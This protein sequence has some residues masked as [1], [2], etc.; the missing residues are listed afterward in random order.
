MCLNLN[1]FYIHI[2][3][4]ECFSFAEL[5]VEILF[6]LK[7]EIFNFSIFTIK[8]MN[9]KNTKVNLCITHTLR[10]TFQPYEMHQK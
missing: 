3:V 1:L 8:Y 4:S 9:N 10:D 5:I 2:L 6:R 7:S